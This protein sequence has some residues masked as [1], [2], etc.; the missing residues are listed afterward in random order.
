MVVATLACSLTSEIEEVTPSAT[1]FVPTAD[2]DTS[3]GYV[4]AT[5][6]I[7]QR[8][9]S[10]ILETGSNVRFGW[11]QP[12]SG[13]IQAEF[14]LQTFNARGEVDTALSL[15]ID[16]TLDDGFA[17]N[18]QVAGLSET[19]V[20]TVTVIAT[21]PDGTQ[22]QASVPAE[23]FA[24]VPE[25]TTVSGTLSVEPIL[26]NDG[27]FYVQR[28]ATFTITWPDAPRDA[29][30]VDFFAGPSGTDTAS[31]QTVFATDEDPT[32][33]TSI[34]YSLPLA[35]GGLGRVYA[36]AYFADGRAPISSEM[37]WIIAEDF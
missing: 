36:T 26:R 32:D 13:A 11:I 27:A 22:R 14:F 37:T 1:L 31:L 34:S 30:R 20:S 21:M 6:F 29:T 9:T 5:P 19:I 17:V 15:G 28:G 25:F 12:P 2:P 23:L 10:Y 8:E 24:G 35:A 7:I 18:W 16:T 3:I 33:G 4:N